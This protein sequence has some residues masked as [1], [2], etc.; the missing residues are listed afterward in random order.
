MQTF[1]FSIRYCSP[2]IYG[3]LPALRFR[4]AEENDF[5]HTPLDL[6]PIPAF[7][8]DG[9][10]CLVDPPP[11]SRMN[12]DHRPIPLLLF[13]HDESVRSLAAVLEWNNQQQSYTIPEQVMIADYLLE[14]FTISNMHLHQFFPFLQIPIHPRFTQVYHRFKEMP[15]EIKMMLNRM[16][17]SFRQLQ[18]VLS[19][20]EPL[21]SSLR[22][23][24]QKIPLKIKIALEM[25]QYL[26]ALYQRLP[27][28]EWK[29]ELK[30]IEELIGN[31]SVSND[32]DLR[33]VLM[34]TAYPQLF[35]RKSAIDRIRK[36]W[37]TEHIRI[38]V[39][40]NLEKKELDV[41]ISFSSPEEFASKIQVLSGEEFL[42]QLKEIFRYL[43]ER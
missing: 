15:S 8:K 30:R 34:D 13:E 33:S 5:A 41:Q 42:Q 31:G 19:F 35:R 7:I 16:N 22:V 36:K 39:D 25:L 9:Q 4:L 23:F 20:P 2:D 28:D 40:P 6:F 18:Q 27:A 29:K 32:E 11:L 3:S 14:T 43:M 24:S 12:P 38:L 1:G 17:P 26:V 10:L 37:G 21:L